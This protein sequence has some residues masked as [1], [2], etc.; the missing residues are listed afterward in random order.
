MVNSETRAIKKD[1][2]YGISTNAVR[3]Y[4]DGLKERRPLSLPIFQAV[5]FETQSTIQ[6]GKD[7]RAGTDQVYTRFGNPSAQ[8][9]GE[10]VALL[11]GAE[12]GLV[13]SSGMGAIS[14][15]LLA[16]AGNSGGHVIAQREI[17]AQTFRL[18]ETTFHD[19]NIETTFVPAGELMNIRPLLMS[20]TKLIYIESPSNPLLKVVDIAGVAIIAKEHGVPLLID[21]TFASPALQKPISLGADVVLHSATKFLAG[22]SDVLCGAVAGSRRLVQ[23]IQRMQVLLGTI[24]DPHACWLLLRGI[25]T[26]GVRVR[27]Q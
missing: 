24:L 3:T 4:S 14:T 5:N 17:F 2:Q 13:F 7:Y 9:A 1:Q 16:L 8:A 21:S 11:E 12:A 19:L 23:K 18:L 20:N 6:L 15:A 22:H 26:L 10:K 25:K 27:Q